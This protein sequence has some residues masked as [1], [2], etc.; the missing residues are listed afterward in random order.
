MLT[1]RTH[2]HAHHRPDR[3]LRKARAAAEARERF[4]LHRRPEPPVSRH[5]NF[6]NFARSVFEAQRKD[7]EEHNSPVTDSKGLVDT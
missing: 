2:A 3:R 4:E 7:A 1:C 5:F 6:E